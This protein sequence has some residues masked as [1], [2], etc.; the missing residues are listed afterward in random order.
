MTRNR[1][2]LFA[3]L[4]L[5]A[6]AVV[7]GVPAGATA[8]LGDAGTL[9]ITY[10]GTSSLQVKLGDGTSVPSGG[11]IPAGSYQ[12]LVDDPDDTNPRFTMSGP[13]VSISSD[14][15]STGMG[16]DRPAM[17]GPYTLQTSA[18]YRVADANM[19]GA[20]AVTFTT[21]ATASA[22]GGSGS[23]GGTSG[24]GTSGGGTSGGGTSSGSTG[25]KLLGTLKAA[26][27]ASGK[28]TLSFAG[29][30][31][32]S[33]H[34]GRYTVSVT[35]HSKKAGFVVGS[36]SVR[37]MTLSGTARTGA[38]SHTVTLSTGRWFFAPSARG[39][40]TYFNVA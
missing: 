33:L 10:V 8:R 1:P 6:C 5:C 9:Q 12:V 19:S 24:G 39:R 14:L 30:A 36:A 27:A 21:S 34:K 15:N 16:I 31:V 35:D 17:F 2:S 32:H 22:G 13:G 4:A 38:S 26:V 7:L 11:T 28:V 3:P 40:K 23:G 37:A 29:S 25:T 20:S 18:S